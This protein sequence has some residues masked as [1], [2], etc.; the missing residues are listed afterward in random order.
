VKDRGVEDYYRNFNFG[1]IRIERGDK[2]ATV[3]L[4][5]SPSDVLDCLS[6]V[7]AFRGVLKIC[8]VKGE[9]REIDCIFKGGNVCRFELSWE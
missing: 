3:D 7:G 1:E 6:W 9:V 4:I 2:M 8:N 5:D